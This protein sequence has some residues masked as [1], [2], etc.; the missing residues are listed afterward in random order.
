MDY[1]AKFLSDA[2]FEALPY[3]DTEN[4]SGLYDPVSKKAYVRKTGFP[5]VDAFT[6]AHELRHM[7][8]HGKG[9]YSDHFKNGVYYKS[10]DWIMPVAL[11]AASLFMP[12]L[13]PSIFPA[14]GAGGAALG[15]L[16]GAG[17]FGTSMLGATGADAAGNSLG[18]GLMSGVGAGLGSS[19]ASGAGMAGAGAAAGGGLSKAITSG[20]G[21]M[22]QDAGK[23]AISGMMAPKPQPNVMPSQQSQGPNPLGVGSDFTQ[24]TIQTGG[25]SQ[26]MGG[27]FGGGSL[28][29]QDAIE[30]A[31]GS[32]FGRS[33]L[34]FFGGQSDKF[35]LPNSGRMG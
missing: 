20:A 15:G 34:D 5:L 31:K 25:P 8:E 27:A 29:P 14:M 2:E 3:Q 26:N 19:L 33:P 16:G 11:G 17:T 4:S 35:G 21:Q 6:L 1:E 9:I 7:D 32:M 23:Q 30:R 10:N 28:N 18:T 24:N 13:L 22:A 12:A